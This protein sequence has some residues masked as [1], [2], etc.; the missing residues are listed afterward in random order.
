MVGEG[1]EDAEAGAGAGFGGD[2]D[3]AAVV[4]DD[5]LGDEEAEAGAFGFGGVVG[6]EETGNLVGR[7]A[8]A[9]VEEGDREPAVVDGKGDFEGTAVGH[10]FGGVFDEVEINLLDLKRIEL[11]G[12]KVGGDVEGDGDAA[13]LKIGLEKEEGVLEEL[14]GIDGL[15]LGLGGTKGEEELGDDGVEAADFGACDVEEVFEFGGVTGFE[16]ALEEL[17]VDV[18]GVERVADFVGDRGGKKADGVEALGFE[19]GRFLGAVA[20]DVAQNDEQRIVR[21][22]FDRQGVEA[23]NARFRGGDFDFAR[24]G[25]G[26]VL[27][28]G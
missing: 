15:E 16:F 10:G 17:E 7:D 1:Q 11:E 24:D 9:G 26:P 23:E 6:L 14:G 27:S 25:A 13:V 28:R 2:F 19:E 8:V 12:G 4:L 5:A 18:E 22:V 21:G 3:L 20:G